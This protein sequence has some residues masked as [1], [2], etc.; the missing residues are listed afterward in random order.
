[1]A[2][3]GF[4]AHMTKAL[5]YNKNLLKGRRDTTAYFSRGKTIYKYKQATPKDIQLHRIKAITEKA[6]QTKKMLIAAGIAIFVSL[7]IVL[8][9]F[10]FV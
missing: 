7:G 8:L 1:M 10:F 4:L 6:R 9:L 3:G 2:G 5:E